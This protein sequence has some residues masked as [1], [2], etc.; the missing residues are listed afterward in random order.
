MK[1]EKQVTKCYIKGAKYLK[2]QNFSMIK[3]TKKSLSPPF[4]KK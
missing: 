4:A 2:N 3:T 1:C